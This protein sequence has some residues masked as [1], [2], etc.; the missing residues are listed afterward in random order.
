MT[1]PAIE[2]R[3]EQIRARFSI[4][5]DHPDFEQ[6][7]VRWV[8]PNDSHLPQR[9]LNDTLRQVLLPT[10][11]K[12]I[13]ETPGIGTGRLS[14][15]LDLLERAEQQLRTGLLTSVPGLHAPST[16]VDAAPLDTITWNY[17]G[18]VIRRHRLENYPLGRFARALIEL[19]HGLWFVPIGQ[20]TTSPLDQLTNLPGY[21]PARVRQVLRVL[22]DL[23][24]SLTSASE[25]GH[26]LCRLSTERL[27]TVAVWIEEV[28]ASRSVPAPLAMK[29][30]FI[31][32]LLEQLATDLGADDSDLVR[33]RWGVDGPIATLEVLGGELNLTRE[34][35]RQMTAKV[36]DVMR[37]RWPEGRH[38]L[39]DFYEL[40]QASPE[41]TEQLA[42]CRTILD[43][44]FEL[45]LIRGGSRAEVVAA[46]ERAGRNKLTPMTEPELRGWLAL[47]FPQ[48]APELAQRWLEECS[49]RLKC[50]GPTLYFSHDRLDRLLHQLTV[51]G[52]SM[53]LEEACEFLQSEERAVRSRIDRDSRF[54]E[55]EEKR[56]HPSSRFSFVRESGV[57]KIRLEPGTEG[58]VES[59]PI[60]HLVHLFVGGLLQRGV[61][62]ATVWGVHRYANEQMK[63]L[64]GVALPENVTAV[65]LATML[66]WH[67]EGLVRHM[68]RRRL[69][70][71][72]A[73][74]SIPVRGKSGWVNHLVSNRGMPLTLEEIG[75]DLRE[76]YQDYEDYVLN[77][78]VFDDED[79]T[80][81]VT[82]RTTAGNSTRIPKM[83]I[84][85]GWQL[86]PDTVNIS[87]G[88]RRFVDRVIASEGE[89][90]FSRAELAH[91]PWVIELCERET[92]GSMIWANDETP[93]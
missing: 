45:K 23:A 24:E 41:A 91:I 48:L 3:Y 80:E 88:V 17:W 25:N 62:D 50:S 36:A 87:D 31:E 81:G 9:V 57:W 30:Q 59:I 86:S 84:P 54:V 72:T 15:L 61:A 92:G 63:R 18:N 89:R 52:A 79:E 77:Q 32:P 53:P 8:S 73:D 37:V 76:Y 39:D 44:C 6:S 85:N 56:I 60:G 70:W 1:D 2:A 51:A 83:F 34:R 55:D 20:F 33:R 46:W 82:F 90:R 13:C 69:R 75:R 19:P 7:I 65:T 35:I 93:G 12:Q 47:E 42:L 22:S 4:I 16:N 58:R 5:E 78:I 10:R 43:A 28:L 11:W 14:K 38:L 66:T 21:G 67:S 49:L 71:D 40:L 68:L 64:Y 29:L 26:L 27:H 74:S